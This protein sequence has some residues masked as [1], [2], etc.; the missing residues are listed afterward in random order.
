MDNEF[1]T[2]TNVMGN[3]ALH[4]LTTRLRERSVVAEM[5]GPSVKVEVSQEVVELEAAPEEPSK[6]IPLLPEPPSTPLEEAL[7]AAPRVLEVPPAPRAPR[8]RWVWPATLLTIALVLGF[9]G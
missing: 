4:E 8:H 3:D 7:A 6:L 5:P 9:H 1:E 2:P